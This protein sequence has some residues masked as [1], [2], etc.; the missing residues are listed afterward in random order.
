MTSY[1][2]QAIILGLTVTLLVVGVELLGAFSALERETIG[3]RFAY[4]R[5]RDEPLSAQIRFVDIDDG[6][7]DSVGRWPWPRSKLADALDEL[8]RAGAG[9]IAIDL[10]LDDT[11]DPEYRPRP[12][13]P[14]DHDDNLAEAGTIALDL[15]LDDGQNPEYRPGPCDRIDH[16]ARN[17]E[18]RHGS[19]DRID[20]DGNLAEALAAVQ[21]VLAVQVAEPESFDAVWK[22]GPGAVELRRLLNVLSRDIQLD[23]NQAVQK[24]ELTEP[25]R[26][27]FL[28]RPLEF[29]KIAAYETLRQMSLQPGS[30]LTFE[31]FVRAVAPGVGEHT[32]D[33]PEL[34]LLCDAWRQRE[35]WRLVRRFLHPESGSSTGSYRDIAPLP[36]FAQHAKAAGFVNRQDDP[37]GELRSIA[38]L[39]PGAGHH[40]VQFGLAA[41]A[42]HL[43][44][45]P[46]DI[47][48]TDDH[49]V[50]G[51]VELPLVAG[52]LWLA[53][54]TTET[55]WS[56]ALRRAETERL[57][58]GHISIGWLIGLAEQRRTLA[59]HKA[60][61]RDLAQII[62][63]LETLPMGELPQELLEEVR[64]DVREHLDYR[65]ELI[66]D[67]AQFTQQEEADDAPYLEWRLLNDAVAS[68]TQWID[69]AEE[70]TRTAE[71]QDKLV[72]IG[73]TA[74]A[75]G[76]DSV[77][78]PLGSETPGVFVHAV[79]A[80][81][82]L[83]GR[84]VRLAPSWTGWALAALLG[85]LCTSLA[86][87][88]TP[89]FSTMFVLVMLAGYVALA[90][91]W[92]FGWIDSVFPMVAPVTAGAGSW[93]ACTA[94]K[95]TLFQRDRRRI[96]RRFK[97]R[98]SPRLVDFLI[99]NP[100]ALSMTGEKREVTVM[101]L[102][103][104][105]FT[106]IIES[107]DG[108]VAVDA[109]NRCMSEL[110]RHIRHH[111][112]Y[113]NKFLGD[114]LMAFWSP[115]RHDP[116]QAV[117]ACTSALE[118]RDGLARL[119]RSEGFAHLPSF[120]ARFGIATGQVIVGDCG[121]PPQLNDYTVIGN[122]V[123]LA[124]RLESANKQF[125]TSILITGRTRDQ[126][127]GAELRTR[128]IGRIIV[129]GQTVPVNVFELLPSDADS[130]MI[131]LTT[132]AI[133]A[134][135][136]REYPASAAAW[137]RLTD[138]FGPSKLAE[139]YLEAIVDPALVVNGALR[140][141][142]K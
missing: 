87:R 99:E 111:E 101:F 122:E 51:E 36:R 128:P 27:R 136:R 107:L 49:L 113:V 46:T 57:T 3:L 38:P 33:Y 22:T 81:M 115:F 95:A 80:D 142:E 11:E 75:V 42:L 31:Q 26:G 131:E 10:L 53:W 59:R 48:V 65:Q 86:A 96:I 106:A 62:L 73:M 32:G 127:D 45:P 137:K 14:I 43:R 124:A 50:L 28:D 121:A 123:N 39:L 18:Y 15:I 30:E 120:S 64:G 117:R 140:L 34:R 21:C 16:D 78:T 71:L 74:T 37:D 25:R 60:R 17:P 19:F 2:R 141:Q 94:L 138:T 104:V 83:S 44:L 105:G 12:D 5:W 79:V 66:D 68:G 89:A 35:A 133:E 29:K 61:R 114:G 52:Q 134:F 84:R 97:S 82:A 135:A 8:R 77:P 88:L 63:N 70:K 40:A 23:S 56:G 112:G 139:F 118:C 54:P 91:W 92:F 9:T 103:F 24:A 6:A 58:A 41:A 4:A 1:A 129:V 119:N 13:D 69:D 98:V 47:R 102:D 126:L 116:D 55:N 130:T 108:A 85:L 20:H 90:G 72:F 93:I 7:L 110:I 76:T 109:L 125:G 67:G 100:D 132:Q